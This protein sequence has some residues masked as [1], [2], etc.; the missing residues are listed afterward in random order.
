MKGPV[1]KPPWCWSHVE[2]DHTVIMCIG[3]EGH[4]LPHF[5]VAYGVNWRETDGEVT[6]R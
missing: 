2:W 1:N 3:N 4:D 5:N 6:E